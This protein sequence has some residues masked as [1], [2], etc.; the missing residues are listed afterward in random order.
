LTGKELD[1]T[2]N[3]T[4]GQNMSH[5]LTDRLGVQ[6]GMGER[7]KFRAWQGDDVFFNGVGNIQNI[8]PFGNVYIEPDSAMTIEGERGFFDATV[9]MTSTT[10]C[11]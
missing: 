2:R 4:K 7:V 6:I 9:V 5:Y 3:S 8:D 10:L 1:C 11:K